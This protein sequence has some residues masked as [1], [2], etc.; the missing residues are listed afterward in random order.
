[1][2]EKKTVLLAG[3]GHAHLEVIKALS[4]DEIAAHR[5]V[6]VS[7][8][9][10][11]YY[12]GL[13]PRLMMGDVDKA[14]LTIGSANFAEAKGIQFLRDSIFSFSE[15]Q[16]EVTLASGRIE[17]FDLLSLNVGG[18][19]I[20]LP[21]ASPFETVYLRPFDDFLPRWREVQRICSSCSNPRFV[22]VGGG[23]AAVEVAT[24]LR[25][26][27]NRN[28]AKSSEVHLVA[29]GSRLCE[30]YSTSTSAGI[31]RSI[32]ALKIR[33]HLNVS[34]DAIGKGQISLQVGEQLGFDAIFIVI[35]TMPSKLS[36]RKIDST[37]R[38]APHIFGVGDGTS[39]QD[40][41]SLPRSGVIAVREGQ[42]LIES[43]R[44]ILRGEQPKE[45]VVPRHQLNILISGEN[46]ARAVWG[47]FSI[48]GH[49]PFRVKS[50]IDEKYMN[51]FRLVKRETN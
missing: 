3:S 8:F 15:S 18:S 11:T 40:R 19:P 38:L 33:V 12:S 45:F 46:T 17:K 24:A 44:R 16:N 50:W 2:N 47:R 6:L 32:L 1:M 20:L 5:F 39:M 14:K 37:L 48:E 9:R 7:P 31:L 25:I 42:H 28:Q 27:L 4:R 21:T 41:P 49:L 26:H 43:I 34:V 51:G 30:N 36:E 29:R 22:V 35:P 23:A 13:I 10:E